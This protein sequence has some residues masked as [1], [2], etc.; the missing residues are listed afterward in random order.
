MSEALPDSPRRAVEE[1][2]RCR[3]HAGRVREVPG[4]CLKLSA[5]LHTDREI[6]AHPIV[7]TYLQ[8][9]L[10]RSAEAAL[11]AGKTSRAAQ[12][13]RFSPVPAIAESVHNGKA[14]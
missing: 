8:M 12:R 4:V 10:A 2:G 11:T 13:A 9:H 6:R 14:E 5:P 3:A 1:W 7:C